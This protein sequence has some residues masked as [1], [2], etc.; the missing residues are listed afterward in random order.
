MDPMVV[1]DEE[2][3]FTV[4]KNVVSFRFCEVFFFHLMETL[5]PFLL[6]AKSLWKSNL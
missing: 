3:F 2:L 1:G 6:Q 4:V 5:P